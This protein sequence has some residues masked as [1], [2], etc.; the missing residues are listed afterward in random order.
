MNNQMI[1]SLSILTFILSLGESKKYLLETDDQPGESVGGT[2]DGEDYT[3]QINIK[4]IPCAERTGKW[5]CP[6]EMICEQGNCIPKD[7]GE[8]KTYL[9]ET[10]DEDK[11]DYL[12]KP[13]CEKASDCPEPYNTC[14]SRICTIFT[15]IH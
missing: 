9:V 5:K 14:E 8:P 10:K 11:E 13:E 2:D 15:T 1:R 4:D 6:E 3:N 12:P 7:E